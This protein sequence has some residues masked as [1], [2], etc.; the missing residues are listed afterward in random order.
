M[1]EPT[2]SVPPSDKGTP[3]EEYVRSLLLESEAGP[4]AAALFEIY[5]SDIDQA[6]H[7]EDHALH[8]QVPG[9][10]RIAAKPGIGAIEE[11]QTRRLAAAI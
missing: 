7:A 5:V 1:P 4:T 10:T 3:I 11:K 6:A 8:L 9:S 2:Q